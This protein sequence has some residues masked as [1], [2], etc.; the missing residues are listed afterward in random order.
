MSTSVVLAASA[1]GMPPASSRRSVVHLTS[2][3]RTRTSRSSDTRYFSS[4]GDL[5]RGGPARPG[6][7]SP[8]TGGAA[9]LP[10]GTAGASG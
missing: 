2:S 10:A 4:M 6:A 7:D 3:A 5:L 9:G 1:A 8:S